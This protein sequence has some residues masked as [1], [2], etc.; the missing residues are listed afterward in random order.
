MKVPS[1]AKRVFNIALPAIGE[2]YLQSLLGV[3][4]SF[5]IAKLGLLAINAVGVT[6]IY[7]MTYIGVFTAISATLSVFL[8]RAF[9]AKDEKR[10]KAVIF[11]ALFISVLIGVLFSV[12]SVAFSNSL[13]EMVGANTKLKDTA[14]F[15][16]KVILGLTPFIALYTTQSASFRAVGD[17]KT[18]FRVGIEMNINH[19]I[20]DYV[21]IF[22]I[23]TFHGLGL[24]G[25]A[26]AMILA[27]IY[28]FLRLV[29]I[30]QKIPAIALKVSDFKVVWNLTVSMIKFAVPATVE[31]LSMRLGQVIYFG[32][33]VRMG[34][35]V[36][37][38]HNIAGTLT[39]F[40]STIGGGFAVAAST[41]IGQAIGE[42]NV[43]DVKEYRK[44]SYLQSAISMTVITGLLAL[45][46][47]WLGKLFTHNETVLHLLMIILLIDTIS[48]PF[49]ASVLVDT[50]VVQA[51]G[52]STFPMLVT[53]I[54]I[55]GVRTLGVYLFAWKLGFGLPAVWLSIAADNAL[56]SGLFVWYRKK[57]NV[58]K[59][60]A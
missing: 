48:Q 35:E 23:G 19:V 14:D 3:V 53:M 32:L 1:K 58:I 39:T 54:G 13:L 47:P 22:G 59:A 46:S 40:A 8:S 44:W 30:S 49:L 43:N 41:L 15:Y 42:N 34:T 4:D 18:P 28:G 9:G 7:S 57:K 6:N 2:S 27:R 29:I 20:L 36:Y 26:I 16:F 21:L 52:N 50:F 55:W 51:G 60:L 38:T 10:S 24:T 11:H 5:F 17:T 37:A 31:R 25:A 12:F 56:R 45:A 33:I